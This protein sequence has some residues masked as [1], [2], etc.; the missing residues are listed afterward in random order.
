MI[1]RQAIMDKLGASYAWQSER[2]K[3]KKEGKRKG[4][5]KGGRA[6]GKGNDDQTGYHELVG[7]EICVG[8]C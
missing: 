4:K 1:I 7:C 2:R 5:G 3:R 8:I 6:M